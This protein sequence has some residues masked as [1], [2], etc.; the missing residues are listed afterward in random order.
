MPKASI[1]SAWKT[2]AAQ[3]RAARENAYAPYSRFTVGCALEDEKGRVFTGCNIENANYSESLCAER[4]AVVKM[5]SEGGRRAV[6]L[7]L[8]TS[9]DKPCFPCGSCLQVLQEFGRPVVLSMDAAGEHFE[10]LEFKSLLPRPFSGED[11]D[12]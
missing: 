9:S 10:E 8:V 6:R 2:L 7:A 4:T 3:A 5:A 1:P 12:V 11:L